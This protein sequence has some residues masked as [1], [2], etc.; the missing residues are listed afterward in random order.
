MELQ[1]FPGWWI[2]NSMDGRSVLA[3]CRECGCVLIGREIHLL[4]TICAPCVLAD[5]DDDG[6]YFLG[7]LMG[8]PTPTPA[9]LV[10][11]TD[12]SAKADDP[13]VVG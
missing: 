10:V 12:D 1:T 6:L 7:G 8:Y 4:A 9:W 2:E 5:C 11:P 3:A 13:A